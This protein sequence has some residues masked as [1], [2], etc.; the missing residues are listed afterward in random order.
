QIVNRSS[1]NLAS[2]D[3]DSFFS[4]VVRQTVKTIRKFKNKDGGTESWRSAIER[5]KLL[6]K[7]THEMA[8]RRKAMKKRL[9]EMIDNTPDEFQDPRKPLIMKQLEMEDQEKA[10]IKRIGREKKE[11]IRIPMKIL[12]ESIKIALAA[13]GKNVTNFDKKTL[14]LFSPRFMSVVP[15][16]DDL[17]NLL[18]PSLFSVHEEGSQAEKTMSLPNLVKALPNKD[19]E[20]WLDFI[21]EAAGVTDAVDMTE[22]KQKE[23]RDK[24][25]RAPD[26]TPLYFTKRNVTKILG[27]TEKRKIETFEELD[28]LYTKRQ[29]RA[30]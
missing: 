26:G 28:K 6:G 5:V 7:E 19:Q 13:A 29:V 16:Q 12:R 3:E 2:P 23:I 11:E 15:E 27:D 8:K 9:R 18:S 14:K 17:F 4:K 22:R 30:E 24:E 25:S 21:V 20:A 10:T 1:Y